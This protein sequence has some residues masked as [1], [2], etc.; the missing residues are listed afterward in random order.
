[1]KPRIASNK[2]IVIKRGVTSE[3]QARIKNVVT[4]TDSR[5]SV[6]NQSC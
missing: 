3:L 4:N 1:M 2:L 5:D 6:K